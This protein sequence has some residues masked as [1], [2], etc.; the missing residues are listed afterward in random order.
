MACAA[1]YPPQRSSP[2]SYAKS[3]AK[4]YV[5]SYAMSYQELHLLV[6]VRQEPRLLL[7]LLFHCA[8]GHRKSVP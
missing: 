7:A 1:S 6:A 8:R 2:T 4:S 3:Y 5:M